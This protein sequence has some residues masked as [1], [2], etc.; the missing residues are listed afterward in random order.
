MK[1]GSFKVGFEVLVGTQAEGERQLNR[2][3][4]KPVPRVRTTF[5]ADEKGV[6]INRHVERDENDDEDGEDGHRRK[7]ARRED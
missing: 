7:R 2:R 3:G 4:V 5:I 6:S 1:P